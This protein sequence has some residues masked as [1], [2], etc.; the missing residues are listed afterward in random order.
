MLTADV[1]SAG[2]PEVGAGLDASD[3]GKGAHEVDSGVAGAIVH[4]DRA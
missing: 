1:D 4:H 3:A 2:I